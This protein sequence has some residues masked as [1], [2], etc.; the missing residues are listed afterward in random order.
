MKTNLLLSKTYRSLAAMLLALSPAT[1]LAQSR[2]ITVNPPQ[3]EDICQF[4][5]LDLTKIT[6][7]DDAG[8][9]KVRANQSTLGTA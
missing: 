4:S 2:A 3:G 5:T 7:Y 9:T 6:C 1:M 8:S